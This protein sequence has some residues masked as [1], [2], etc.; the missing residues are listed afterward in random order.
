MVKSMCLQ[1][2]RWLSV[3]KSLKSNEYRS[4]FNLISWIKPLNVVVI[5]HILVLSTDSLLYVNM[6]IL[7]RE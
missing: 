4:L 6:I 3:K 5:L 1:C 2:S 7:S